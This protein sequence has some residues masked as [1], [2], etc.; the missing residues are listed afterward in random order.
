MINH[1]ETAFLQS[2]NW[3]NTSTNISWCQY[4]SQSMSGKLSTNLIPNSSISTSNHSHSFLGPPPMNIQISNN[5]EQ[6]M[7]IRRIFCTSRN[8]GW[9]KAETTISSKHM[10]AQLAT[11]SGWVQL[12][13]ITF[14]HSL[15]TKQFFKSLPCRCFK[16]NVWMKGSAQRSSWYISMKMR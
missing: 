9:L 15:E 5:F 14:G 16:L 3:V 10:L 6:A 12:S 4:D 1:T 7:E 8:Y 13:N 11:L 2:L